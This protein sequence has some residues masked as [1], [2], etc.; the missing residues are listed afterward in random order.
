MGQMTTVW[1]NWEER[2]PFT[3]GLI[4]TSGCTVECGKG[5]FFLLETCIYGNA[6][7]NY[8]SKE[9]RGYRDLT[10]KL[11]LGVTRP[12]SMPYDSKQKTKDIPIND[13]KLLENL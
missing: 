6:L 11:G 2:A 1:P 8:S 12:D 13:W 7:H 4:K 5:S 3:T 9:A 10:S